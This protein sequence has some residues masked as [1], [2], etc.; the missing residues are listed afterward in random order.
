MRVE[1]FIQHPHLSSAT[2]E[3]SHVTQGLKASSSGDDFTRSEHRTYD[4]TPRYASRLCKK[5]TYQQLGVYLFILLFE[6]QKRVLICTEETSRQTRTVAVSQGHADPR[7]SLFPPH[8][9]RLHTAARMAA[10]RL[11]LSLDLPRC[12][13]PVRDKVSSRLLWLT[14]NPDFGQGSETAL[15]GVKIRAETSGERS[16]L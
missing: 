13:S 4:V 12:F 9:D 14:R 6:S 3:G 1:A 16:K 5:K 7:R 10:G 2:D 15:R 11:L 8:A